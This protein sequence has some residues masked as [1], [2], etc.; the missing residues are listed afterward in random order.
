MVAIGCDDRYE[1]VD[2]PSAA[3]AIAG[4]VNGLVIVVPVWTL[5]ASIALLVVLH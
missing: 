2:S 1:L 5:V 3:P 4:L